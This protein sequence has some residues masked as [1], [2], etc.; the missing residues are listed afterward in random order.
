MV[1]LTFLGAMCEVGASG[2]VLENQSSRV[3]MDYGASTEVT[4]ARPPLPCGK[5]S[6]VILS[7]AHVDHCGSLPM[8]TKESNA[9]IFAAPCTRE[10]TEML[11][12]DSLKINMQAAGTL[13]GASLPFVKDD[14]KRTVSNFR[15][16]P[17]RRPFSLPGG[18][19]A[20][21]FDAG[22][23]PGS[24]MTLVEMDG[25]NFLY[26]GNYNGIDTRLLKKC[27]LDLPRV[28]YLIT[29]STYSDRDHPDRRSQEKELVEMVEQTVGNGGIALIPSFAVGRA[30]ELLLILEQEGIDY[31]VFMDGMAKKASTIINRHKE[32]LRDPKELDDTLRKVKYVTT[33][34]HRAKVVKEP[35]AIITTSGMLSGGPT[36]SYM[37]M[38]HDDDN[39]SLIL[40]GWQAHDSPGKLL[41]ETGRYINEEEKVDVEVRMRVRRLDFSAHIGRTDMWNFIKQ[42]NPKTTFC[43]HGDHT[44]EFARELNEKGFNAVAPIA[45]D[46]IFKF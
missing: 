44:E 31:P 21:L 43:V 12:Y 40:T 24:A 34:Q 9:P 42:L 4:P 29:E 35:C 39:S 46:R 33:Q 36:N 37:K 30:Q 28:D 38:L 32:Q 1:Q 20:T 23:I 18:S 16:I 26:A 3:L 11:L 25:K 17:Y 41:L 10:I 27:D 19:R 45:N 7:H 2:M 22:H 8:V 15:D 13:E 6:S 14:V 5:V